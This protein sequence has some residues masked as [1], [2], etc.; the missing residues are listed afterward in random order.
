MNASYLGPT[1]T[2]FMDAHRRCCKEIQR[3]SS[4]NGRLRDELA[5]ARARHE[6]LTHT[7]EIW[8][9]L[10]EAHL[11]RGRSSGPASTH[12]DAAGS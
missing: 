8:I 9:R 4:E 5:R 6:D 2:Q 3:L 12:L 1:S 11:S 10:Y 7:A